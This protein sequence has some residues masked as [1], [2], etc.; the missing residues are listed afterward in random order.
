MSLEDHDLEAVE[1]GELGSDSVRGD[2]LGPR[3]FGPLLGE[4]EGFDDPPNA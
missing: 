2:L 1:V 4:V 3:G